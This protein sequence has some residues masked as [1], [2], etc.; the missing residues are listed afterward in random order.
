MVLL[1]PRLAFFVFK[2]ISNEAL[3]LK[4]LNLLDRNLY[5]K[6]VKDLSSKSGRKK[7]HLSISKTT[8]EI[9]VCGSLVCSIFLLSHLL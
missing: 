7:I 2:N 9:Q 1:F 5:Q 3:N 6:I 8:G 4:R